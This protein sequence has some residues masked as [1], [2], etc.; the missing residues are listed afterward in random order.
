LF[1]VI[2]TAHHKPINPINPKPFL[3]NFEFPN[4]NPPKPKPRS[5]HRIL[6]LEIFGA[7]TKKKTYTTQGPLMNV[8]EEEK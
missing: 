1:P 7:S 4:P 5:P 8:Q 2:I 3:E 6:F